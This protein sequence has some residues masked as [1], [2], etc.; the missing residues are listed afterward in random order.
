M[1]AVTLGV[2]YRYFTS[3]FLG[4]LSGYGLVIINLDKVNMYHDISIY[5]F[6]TIRFYWKTIN[7]NIES[8][9]S[10]TYNEWCINVNIG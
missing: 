1:T 3:H 4:N 9:L 2:P 10:P 8:S 5:D 7:D 6:I